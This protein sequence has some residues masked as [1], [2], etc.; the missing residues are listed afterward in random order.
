MTLDRR[1]RISSDALFTYSSKPLL[2]VNILL[3]FVFVPVLFGY[4]SAANIAAI[5]FFLFLNLLLFGSALQLHIHRVRKALFFDDYFEV[6]GRNLNKRINYQQVAQ[7]EKVMVTPILTSR[8]QVRISPVGEPP[9][10]IPGNVRSKKLKTDLY[11]WLSKRVE[12]RT[13]DNPEFTH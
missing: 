9:L 11:S 8:T 4:V 2:I 1:K 10:V 5:L 7:V 12:S 3:L 13:P 6:G